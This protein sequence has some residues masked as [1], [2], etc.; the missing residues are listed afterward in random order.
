MSLAKIST[1][2][3]SLCSAKPFEIIDMLR[4]AQ[5]SH[6]TRW[7]RVKPLPKE[8]AGLTKAESININNA[9]TRRAKRKRKAKGRRRKKCRG[10]AGATEEALGEISRPAADEEVVD[11]LEVQLALY[12]VCLQPPSLVLHLVRRHSRR[13][14]KNQNSRELTTVTLVG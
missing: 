9:E 4:R 14:S 10:E 13:K 7:A 2:G 6:A 11:V 1:P 12:R 8:H 3:T 5:S